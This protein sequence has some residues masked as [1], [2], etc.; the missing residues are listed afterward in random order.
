[1]EFFFFSALQMYELHL[2][3]HLGATASVSD[4]NASVWKGVLHFLQCLGTWI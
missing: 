4:V 1:M 2:K 3:F